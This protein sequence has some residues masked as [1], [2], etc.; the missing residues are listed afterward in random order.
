MSEQEHTPKV[1]DNDNGEISVALDGQQVRAW[2]YQDRA[3]FRVKMLAAR[4]FVEGWYQ[5]GVRDA[6][7]RDRLRVLNTELRR[8]LESSQQY[9]MAWLPEYP[10]GDQQ[11]KL[12]M[13]QLD[14]NTAAIAKATGDA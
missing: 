8:A 1:I 5:R 7:E 6:A 9:L 14:R 4:E 11:R 10:V 2:S 12:V 3:E 13:D